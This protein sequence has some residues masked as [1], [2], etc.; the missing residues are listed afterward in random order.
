MPVRIIA[1]I[2][3]S[4]EGCRPRIRARTGKILGADL[5]FKWVLKQKI[6]GL[7]RIVSKPSFLL[8]L[9]RTILAWNIEYRNHLDPLRGACRFVV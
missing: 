9:L 6:R 1:G 8:P 7:A 2:F 4:C 5:N 3:A